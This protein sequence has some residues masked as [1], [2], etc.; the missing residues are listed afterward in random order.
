M[1]NNDYLAMIRN[2]LN[3]TPMDAAWEEA[4]R[5]VRDIANAIQDGLGATMEVS[6]EPGFQTLQGQQI[7]VVLRIPQKDFRDVLFRSY[8]PMDGYPVQVDFF[9]GAPASCGDEDALR[10]H[11]FEILQ[12]PDVRYRLHLLKE[13]TGIKWTPESK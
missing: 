11:V 10:R 1:R 12:R 3:E 13:L 4:F 9:G 7:D 2:L 5:A 8:I 6:L